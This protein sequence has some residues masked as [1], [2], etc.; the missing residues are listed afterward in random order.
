VT[1]PKPHLTVRTTRLTLAA[2]L[3]P[4]LIGCGLRE[5]SR[6]LLPAGGSLVRINEL[7]AANHS[8]EQDEF[9]E[10]DDW[11][12]LYNGGSH[13]AHLEGYFV[14]DNSERPF[15]Y[16]LPPEAMVPARGFLLL[17]ADSEPDEG[18][19]RLWAKDPAMDQGPLHLPFNLSEDGE[20]VELRDP[21][22]NLVD[23]VGYG[24]GPGDHSYARFP[25]GTG[26]FAWCS[27][28]TPNAFN[29][30]ACVPSGGE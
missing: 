20:D 3:V 12:E 28:P 24:W 4:L 26:G 9:A 13:D 1:R 15:K 18:F 8:G 11:I 22:G 29:G 14:T 2:M 19:E 6:G 17:W 27:D 10:Y 23:A 30:S 5:E 7:V 16:A 25:D 21:D